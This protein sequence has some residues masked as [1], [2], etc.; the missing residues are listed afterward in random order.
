MKVN[1][2]NI[3]DEYKGFV[4]DDMTSKEISQL[5][6]LLIKDKWLVLK[7]KVKNIWRRNK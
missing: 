4:H 5:G 3:P 7:E 6:V 1:T 2:S